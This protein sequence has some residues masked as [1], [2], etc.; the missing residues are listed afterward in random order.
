APLRIAGEQEFAVPPLASP[1]DASLD[2]EALLGYDSVQLFVTRATAI[3]P[4]FALTPDN[5]PA[6]AALCGRLDGLPLAIELAAA[7]VRLL[8]P[9]ALLERL[10]Q[11]FD[12]LTGGARDLPSRQRT[13]HGAIAW[14]YD[15]LQP[16]ARRC[17]QRLSV[18][19]GSF[20]LEAAEAV[21]GAGE[22]EEGFD[23]L[24]ALDDLANHSL[25][26]R[27]THPDSNRL[28]L[29]E[30]IR[31]FARDRLV[32]AGDLASA[33]ARHAAYYLSLAEREEPALTSGGQIVSCQRLEAD[34]DN[35]R[36][37][38]AFALETRDAPLGVA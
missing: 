15:L 25:L 16:A 38:L 9:P 32:E 7:R 4:S 23:V 34:H 22:I 6:V 13:L 35:L 29:L 33:R 20:T 11:R 2:V 19:A 17:L 30:T 3:D 18:F 1:A 26:G 37:A 8:P 21:C 31:A 12:V 10:E 28:Y 36:A 24:E 27:R 5:A 14:S